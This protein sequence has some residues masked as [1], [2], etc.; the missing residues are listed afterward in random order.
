ME[1]KDIMQG[2]EK[3]IKEKNFDA[4]YVL[5]IDTQSN[6][7]PKGE[8][9]NKDKVCLLIKAYH[10]F[11]FTKARLKGEIDAYYL[12]AQK[13][14]QWAKALAAECRD[15]GMEAEHTTRLLIKPLLSQLRDFVQ[16]KSTL[17]AHADYGTCFHVQTLVLKNAD[18][19][20]GE[21]GGRQGETLCQKCRLCEEACPNG[22][23]EKGIY[24]REKCLRNHMVSG[25]VVP[26]EM[27]AQMGMK[28]IGCDAC[29]G[30]CPYNQ[31]IEKITEPW[32]GEAEL[33]KLLALDGDYIAALEGKIGKNMAMANRLCAQACLVAA[34][35]GD[36][37]YRP[38]L[39]GLIN[40]PSPV[41]GDHA[42]WAVKNLSN[43]P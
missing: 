2:L 28:L 23:I 35:S 25:K 37:K 5:P 29:Q 31:K 19:I 40:H 9:N 7:D 3:L 18:F 17:H 30:V 14:Y 20:K 1:K 21:M 39:Q 10:P 6:N 12:T 16:L 4:W 26:V 36:E 15:L 27:R 24:N 8:A 42:L 13:S 32:Q 41:V 22:A 34:N 38:A 11:L 33:E 43:E